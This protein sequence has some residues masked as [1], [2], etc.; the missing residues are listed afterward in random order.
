MKDYV[1][2]G[3]QETVGANFACGMFGTTTDQIAQSHPLYTYLNLENAPLCRTQWLTTL[4]ERGLSLLSHEGNRLYV[5]RATGEL[6]QT[7]IH[8]AF[9]QFEK[10]S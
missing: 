6:L 3:K 2:C 7:L 9:P 5:T 8:I 10:A 1:G 4:A